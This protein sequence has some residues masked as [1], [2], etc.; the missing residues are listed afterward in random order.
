MAVFHDLPS[1]PGAFSRTVVTIGNFDGVHL[2]HR[3][4][5]ARV[6]ARAR[7]LGTKPVA[8][9]FDPHPV[10]VLRPQVDLPLLTTPEQKFKLLREAGMEVVVV[11][12]F[13]QTFST[14]S[15]RDFVVRYFVEGLKAREV[16]VGH[17]YSFG[18]KRE[19]TI[20]LLKELGQTFGFTVQVVWAVEVNGAVVSSS[21]IRAMLKLGKVEEANQLLG[22]A[23]MVTGKVIAGKGRG[24]AVLGIPTANIMPENDLLPA[25]GI[26]AVLARRG[27]IILPGV[28]NIGTC[29]TFDNETATSLEVHIFDFSG[30]LYGEKLDVEFIARLREERRFPSI[31]A[32]A[33]Q[34]RADI[35]VA[36]Q[37]LREGR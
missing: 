2:G 33:A 13:T 36:R 34:I 4:I 37:V 21:L 26:Y 1:E 7:D 8:L 24:A 28:A 25:S 19:G 15:A 27:D 12:P 6:A 29:P 30:D 20:D 16:V 17:D 9:T 35:E 23:Y 18:Y 5:L 10:K 31:E 14:I 22:R 11:L 32:L 3:A